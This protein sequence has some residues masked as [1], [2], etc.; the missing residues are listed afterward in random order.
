V[1]LPARVY[2]PNY[3]RG[4][5]PRDMLVPSGLLTSAELRARNQASPVPLDTAPYASDNRRNGI[6]VRTFRGKHRYQ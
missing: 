3:L 1:T 2:N 5:I 4:P 6:L